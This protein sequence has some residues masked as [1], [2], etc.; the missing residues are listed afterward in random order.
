MAK[1]GK[2]LF[3]EY[4]IDPTLL[5]QFQM[6]IAEQLRTEVKDPLRLLEIVLSVN[7]SM[8]GAFMAAMQQSDVENRS[9]YIFTTV[10]E[11]IL[12]FNVGCDTSELD[13]EMPHIFVCPSLNEQTRKE[14][15]ET[16]LFNR[17]LKVYRA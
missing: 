8:S 3:E 5:D 2:E 12:V 17:V 14:S 4:Q 10:E 9:H 16:Y 6:G 11:D 1:T 15:W 7:D 13:L